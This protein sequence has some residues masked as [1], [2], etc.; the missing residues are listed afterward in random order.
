MNIEEE[1]FDNI[2]RQKAEEMK[3][4]FDEKNWEKAAAMLDIERKSVRSSKTKYI[5]LALVAVL[6]TSLVV[7]ISFV[8]NSNSNKQEKTLAQHLS[9]KQEKHKLNS[10]KQHSEIQAASIVSQSDEVFESKTKPINENGQS[11]ISVKENN[12][13]T[14]SSDGNETVL[15]EEKF[16]TEN[17]NPTF[18]NNEQANEVIQ[19]MI[20]TEQIQANEVY[21]LSPVV[22]EFPDI[23]QEQEINNMPFTALQRYDED[24]YSRKAKRKTHYLNVE[25]GGVYLLGWRTE[26]GTD[27]QGADWYG[28]FNYGVYLNKKMNVSAGLQAYN[29]RNINQ[30]FFA[31][32]QTEYDFG[33]VTSNTVIT[34]NNLY[35]LSIPVKFNYAFN[36]NNQIGFGVN[37]GLAVGAENTVQTYNEY[38]GNV[39]SNISTTKN[40]AL[41]DG[42]NSFNLML[43]AS[44]K[45]Q[46]IPKLFFTGEF[47]Y[48]VTDIF[49]NN[50][51]AKNQEQ[52]MGI[53]IGLQYHLFDK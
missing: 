46:I 8:N 10:A 28:G 49:K 23:T 40:N 37:S 20:A 42:V 38:E 15:N 47:I 9:E 36:S 24:Y 30:A 43:T 25:F 22:A 26:K 33:V 11:E 34:S 4:P 17:T 13:A 1:N 12:V 14:I 53:R 29:I 19:E 44:Y 6:G 3:F 41:Y 39:K 18:E 7:G 31:C 32:K 45:A 51:F 48:G 50:N 16:V 2:I 27:G 52:P 5:V 21:L 35:Y